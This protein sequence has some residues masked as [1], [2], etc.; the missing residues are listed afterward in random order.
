MKNESAD[1]KKGTYS[2]VIHL[3]TDVKVNWHEAFTVA[4][5]DMSGT[6]HAF[7]M[8][9]NKPVTSRINGQDLRK[10]VLNHRLAFWPSRFLEPEAAPM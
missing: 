6:Q 1:I 3:T 8:K 2:S 5:I 7:A 4:C 10:S 9:Y